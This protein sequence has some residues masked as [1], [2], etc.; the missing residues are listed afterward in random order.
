MVKAIETRYKGYRFR[1][2]LEARWAVF[3]DTLGVAWE[4]EKEGF[5]LDGEYYLPDFW[6][7]EQGCWVEVKGQSPN[8]REGNLAF[9]LSGATGKPVYIFWGDVPDPETG[10]AHT[11]SAYVYERWEATPADEGGSW[12]NNQMWCECLTCGKVGIAFDG[13]SDRLPCKARFKGG[14]CPTSGHGD[15]GYTNN[16]PRLKRAYTAARSARFEHGESGGALPASRELIVRWRANSVGLS[17]ADGG[18]REWWIEAEDSPGEIIVRCGNDKDWP[19][20]SGDVERLVKVHNE[21]NVAE[22]NRLLVHIS[23]AG[24]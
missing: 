18:G 10:E 6:L 3:F 4:Y 5:D 2:R 13:R 9:A 11:D 16:S 7:P 23:R 1:S 12:D 22:E 21:G 17:D 20:L 24:L 19:H 15:K 8:E 14:T